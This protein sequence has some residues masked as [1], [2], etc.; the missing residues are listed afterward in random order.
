MIKIISGGQTGV[1]RAALDAALELNMECGGWC[2]KG[3]RAEDGPIP[4]KYPLQETKT[5]KYP[6]R[7][8]KNIF[9]A[10]GTLIFTL[11]PPDRGT[12]LTL[13]MAAKMKKPH[14]VVDLS[15]PD[16]AGISD[17]I[18]KNKIAILN[19]AGPRESS[20]PGVYLTTRTILLP[21]LKRFI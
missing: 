12:K 14:H 6:E 8:I 19:I 9:E 11:G 15:S 5:D 7:T 4:S 16:A 20:K 10:D 1:D 17:W 18:T 21:I 3:R 13:S 2:P